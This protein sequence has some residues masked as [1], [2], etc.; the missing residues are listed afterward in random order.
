MDLTGITEFEWF[1]PCRGVTLFEGVF[2]AQPTEFLRFGAETL[3]KGGCALLGRQPHARKTRGRG[4][5]RLEQLGWPKMLLISNLKI[6]PTYADLSS[7]ST[8]LGRPKLLCACSG[9]V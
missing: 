2:F 9:D 3:L 8:I 6:L 1:P 5:Y 4:T 7:G